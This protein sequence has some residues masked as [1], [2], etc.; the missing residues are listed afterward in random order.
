MLRTD[1]PGNYT[2]DPLMARYTQ[3]SEIIHKQYLEAL[4]TVRLYSKQIA[5]LQI[6]VMKDMDTISR[7]LGSPRKHILW[8]YP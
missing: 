3:T 6:E 5:L 2:H 8:I 1:L 4:Q 7:F